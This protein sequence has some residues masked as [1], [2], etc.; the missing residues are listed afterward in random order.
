[1][2]GM[3]RVEL[4]RPEVSSRELLMS[5]RI[6]LVCTLGG[7]M[8]IEA[9]SL[10]IPV[11]AVLDSISTSFPGVCRLDPLSTDFPLRLRSILDEKPG[12]PS[13]SEIDTWYE[14]LDRNSVPIASQA[15]LMNSLIDWGTGQ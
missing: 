8:S 6:S 7:S 1:L 11:V 5:G 9:R 3:P 4:C 12:K 13:E 14:C 15:Q 10:G 2:K